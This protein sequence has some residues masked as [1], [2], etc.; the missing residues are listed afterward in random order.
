M[1]LETSGPRHSCPLGY[2]FEMW[3][4]GEH[5]W[6]ESQDWRVA[7]H[8]E[9]RRVT[10]GNRMRVPPLPKMRG[11]AFVE[12]V[13]WTPYWVKSLLV[14]G[15]TGSN[16]GRS[17]SLRHSKER[18]LKPHQ[19]EHR[20]RL[21]APPRKERLRQKLRYMVRSHSSGVVYLRRAT[22]TSIAPPKSAALAS[23]AVYVTGSWR[24]WDLMAPFFTAR[25]A[26]SMT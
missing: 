11:P 20:R 16:T 7:Y 18:D 8:P 13:R 1:P 21:L 12:I 6:N 2:A 10:L 14:V 22:T 24:R 4:L 9:L 26:T 5:R 19:S 3:K 23:P 25:T 17:Q 15:S